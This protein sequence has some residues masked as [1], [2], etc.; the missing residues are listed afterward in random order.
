MHLRA[1]QE[2]RVNRGPDAQNEALISELLDLNRTGLSLPKTPFGWRLCKKRLT[3]SVHTGVISLTLLSWSKDWS[4]LQ[5]R[6]ADEA[7]ELE[8]ERTECC[9]RC[10]GG[11]KAD[12]RDMILQYYAEERQAKID[13]RKLLAKKL[14]LTTITLRTRACRIRVRLE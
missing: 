13:H 7:E 6:L 4:E 3:V 12:D 5:L 9:E 14:G 11:L 2:H 8:P 10:L 1:L